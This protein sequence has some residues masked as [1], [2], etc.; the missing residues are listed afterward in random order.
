[1]VDAPVIEDVE[2]KVEDDA[3]VNKTADEDGAGGEADE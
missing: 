2:E 3:S 1:L